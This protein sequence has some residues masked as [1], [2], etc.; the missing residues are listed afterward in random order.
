MVVWTRRKSEQPAPRHRRLWWCG[1][2][3][4]LMVSEISA[5]WRHWCFGGVIGFVVWRE[6]VE[7]RRRWESVYVSSSEASETLVSGVLVCLPPLPNV[8]NAAAKSRRCAAAHPQAQTHLIQYAKRHGPT[9]RQH[10]PVPSAVFLEKPALG[11][12]PY[13][14]LGSATMTAGSTSRLIR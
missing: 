12:S 9:H 3:D 1:G 7:L 4:S 8:P 13:V 11:D 6:E 2:P 5:A 10:T 14:G